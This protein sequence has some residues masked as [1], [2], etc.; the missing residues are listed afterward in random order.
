[1]ADINEGRVAITHFI[2][3]LEGKKAPFDNHIY[4]SAHGIYMLAEA[5]KMRWAQTSVP[6]KD[7]KALP[8]S[9]RIPFEAQVFHAGLK[10]FLKRRFIIVL[11]YLLLLLLFNFHLF[12]IFPDR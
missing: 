4:D 12:F 5:F 10:T 2:H 8:D 9:L 3:G 1:M 7:F 11:F 6:N